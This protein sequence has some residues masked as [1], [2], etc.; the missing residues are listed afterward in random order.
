MRRGYWSMTPRS[1]QA[2]L[3]DARYAATAVLRFADGKSFED[4]LSDELLRSAIERQMITIGEALRAALSLDPSL[5]RNFPDASQIVAFRNR[6]VHG[7]FDINDAT[8]WAIISGEL[9][10]MIETI[11][12]L[13]PEDPSNPLVSS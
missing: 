7:Y 13:L 1:P 12:R 10:S 8:V 4:Y 11:N 2:Y 6:V 3:W 5:A 9:P